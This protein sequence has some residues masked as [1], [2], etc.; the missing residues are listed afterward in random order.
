MITLRESVAP[1]PRIA[2]LLFGIGVSAGLLYLALRGL[3]W[4]SL[5]TVAGDSRPILLLASILLISLGL[6]VRSVR[7]RNLVAT[8]GVPLRMAFAAN[9]V[10]YLGNLLL[11]ARAGELARS[12]VLGRRSGL[13]VTHVLAASL[14]ERVLDALV[15]V[16]IVLFIVSTVSSIDMQGAVIP[17]AIASVAAL[18]ALVTIACMPGK[19]SALLTRMPLPN[20]LRTT[21]D[22][23]VVSFVGGLAGLRSWRRLRHFALYTVL[24]WSL[25]GVTAFVL[26]R[27]FE[28]NITWPQGMLLVAILGLASAVPSTP[29][30]IGVYQFVAVTV[31]VPLGFSQAQALVYVTALQVCTYVVVLACGGW[32]LVE[33]N[34]SLGR[35][36]TLS[37]QKVDREP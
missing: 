21:L 35:L 7:W 2:L 24:V 26:A 29:G 16:I 1:W 32:A 31:L 36:F 22:S 13:G 5:A 6:L 30:Y 33:L 20:R 27:A 18:A 14:T 12:V 28:M 4:A 3:D 11:P 25:D 10:G 9:S 23:L 37:R 15:L 8:G 19:V 17:V 34:L